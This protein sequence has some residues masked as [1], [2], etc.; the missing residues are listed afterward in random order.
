MGVSVNFFDNG[1]YIV[2]VK[3]LFICR[4]C[5]CWLFVVLD[6]T[7]FFNFL[8][9]NISSSFVFRCLQYVKAIRKEFLW[10]A[11]WV[12]LGILS[13]V[14][15][16][17][18]LHTFLLYLVSRTS[19]TWIPCRNLRTYC[20]TFLLCGPANVIVFYFHVNALSD[21]YLWCE[22]QQWL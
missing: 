10:C 5:W 2:E 18:G 6:H 3:C 9:V 11:Y 4:G 12:G 13:S 19:I 15:L 14:G 22:T 1:G 16:G 21:F 8:N 20:V 7:T 17:T